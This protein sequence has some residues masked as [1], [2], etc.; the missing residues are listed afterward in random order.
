MKKV[1]WTL[2][3]FLAMLLAA[4][5]GKDKD[6]EGAQLQQNKVV[7]QETE[8]SD[9]FE[10]M[11]IAD[12][13]QAVGAIRQGVFQND[14]VGNESTKSAVAETVENGVTSGET[15]VKES[16]APTAAP[17]DEAGEASDEETMTEA[18]PEVRELT[19]QELKKLQWSVRSSDNGFFVSTYYRPEEIDWEQVFYNGAGIKLNVTD[20]QVAL[21]REKLR[22]QRLEEERIKAELMGI[23][24]EEEDPD[25]PPAEPEFTQEEQALNASQ[26]TAL[27]LR[28]IQNFV[29]SRTGLEY[30]EARK[31]LEWPELSRNVYYFIH[32]DS[33]AI[34]LEFMSGTV[35]GSTYEV[36]Y[37]RAVWSREKKPEYVIR[38]VK[39][40]GKWTFLSNLPIDEAKPITLADVTY[41][42][43]KEL[44]RMQNPVEI[45]DVE[46]VSKEDDFDEAYVSKP[47][48]EPK[49]YWAVITAEEDNCQVT[50]ERVY[51]GDEICKELAKERYYVPGDAIGTVS[52]MAGEK[53]CVKVTLEDEPQLR[54]RV[55]CGSYYGDYAFGSENRLKRFDQDGL[56]KSTYVYGRDYDGEH[57]GTDFQSEKELLRLMEGTWLFY[58]HELGEYTAAVSFDL[59]GDMKIHTLVQDYVIQISGYDR[60]YSDVRSAPPDVI[61]LKAIDEKTLELFTTYYP[62]MKKKVGDYRVR[63]MQMDGEQ[64]LI[65][66]F[67]NNGKDGLTYLLPGAD[68]LT[69][70]IVLYRF[71]GTKQDDAEEESKG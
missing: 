26:I 36:Y 37:R 44:A 8:E 33:N 23:E 43:S 34:R 51:L 69:D 40:D 16:V 66:S 7:M 13:G 49:Y 46:R 28:S 63:T 10:A 56:P 35:C 67:E 38:F 39:E 30:S 14:P 45:F 29:K 21:I 5:C 50:V 1:K 42:S 19:E 61:K 59:N 52:L 3:I 55:T 17:A 57:R 68:P 12:A 58:D 15:S 25:A 60:M 11:L 70:E 20:D 71:R 53:I 47:A 32:N 65:L 4:G 22:D 64:M 6:T 54:V 24:P 27:T 18:E 62:F 41:V 9:E 31:P 48:Q 2:G